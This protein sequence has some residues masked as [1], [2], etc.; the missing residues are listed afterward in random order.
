M[1]VAYATSD[2]LALLLGK[3]SIDVDRAYL[4]IQNASA[5]FSSVADTWWAPLTTTYTVPGY[6]RCEILLPFRP[7]T[8]VTQVKVAGNVVTDTT[9][10][11]RTLY[12]AAG[13]G[14]RWAYPPDKVE[15]DVSY[16]YDSAPDD[17]RGA[18]LESVSATFSRP[19]PSVI[20]TRADTFELR[21]S[22]PARMSSQKA[23]AALLTPGANELALS[24]A[25]SLVG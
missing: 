15:V 12:R 18:V 13:F 19:D 9:L 10:I 23:H 8:A 22:D 25:G 20:L 14:T 2:D 17:V 4:L 1:S 16:G 11:Q 5:A 24:Y 21:F 7:L 6:G 3:D